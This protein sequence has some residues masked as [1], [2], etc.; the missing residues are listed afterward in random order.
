M[1]WK[2]AKISARPIVPIIARC[3]PLV[4]VAMHCQTGGR[5][6]LATD[7]RRGRTDATVSLPSGGMIPEAVFRRR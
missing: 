6:G 5:E 1:A 3:G 4:R 7:G 2:P